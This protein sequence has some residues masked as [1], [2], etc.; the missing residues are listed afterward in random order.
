MSKSANVKVYCRIR[1][2]IEI[3]KQAGL[4]ICINPVSKEAVRI[5][6]EQIP[7]IN[8]YINKE[9]AEEKGYQDFT[10]DAVFG[11]ETNQETVYNNVAK[12]LISAAFEGINCT[13]FCYGQTSSGKTYTIEGIDNNKELLGLIPRAT[14]EIFDIISKG[15]EEIEYSVK[16]QYFQIYNEKIIDLIDSSKSDLPIREDK[17]KGIWVED[18]TDRYVDSEHEMLNF[19][20]EGAKNRKFATTQMNKLSSRSHSIFAVTIF[21]RSTITG[22]SKTGKVY[23]VDLAGSEKLGKTG[24]EGGEKLRE[25][26]NINKSIMTLG[27][28]INALSKSQLHVPYRDSKL[29][30]V[31]QESLGGNSLTNLIINCS[32]SSMNQSETLNTLRFGQRAKLIKNKV[33]ANTVPSI[34]ELLMKLEKSE[35]KIKMLEEI[36]EQMNPGEINENE[37]NKEKK[38]EIGKNGCKECIKLKSKIDYFQKTQFQLQSEISDLSKDKEEMLEEINKKTQNLNKM[39]LRTDS[40]DNSVKELKNE[41]NKIYSELQAQMEKCANLSKKIKNSVSKNDIN[42]VE[43]LNDIANKSWIELISNLGVEIKSLVGSQSAKSISITTDDDHDP[44]DIDRDLTEMEE[45]ISKDPLLVSENEK[46]FELYENALSDSA[47]V[48]KT[49]GKNI[50]NSTKK[51]GKKG[52]LKSNQGLLTAKKKGGFK[53][54]KE[55]CVDKGMILMKNINELR[56]KLRE[57]KADFE[58]ERKNEKKN[59]AGN[60]KKEKVKV[61]E[62]TTK[63]PTKKMN[64]VALTENKPKDIALEIKLNKET[65]AKVLHH[66][67]FSS[68]H[69]KNTNKCS[70]I[71]TTSFEILDLI[72]NSY[73]LDKDKLILRLESDVQEYKEK[74][75]LFESQLTSDEKNLHRKIYTLEKNLEQVNVI[76]QQIITQKSVLK[77]E[78]QIYERKLKKK[79][80]K[81]NLLLKTNAELEEKLK[82]KDDKIHAKFIKVIRGSN[83]G[84]ME[85]NEEKN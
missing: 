75:D 4:S 32:P 41:L 31:L 71:K 3:E 12:P 64:K 78:N 36:I 14:H 58:G 68:T 8:N 33:I 54:N 45:E 56:E 79:N 67:Q 38:V 49:I 23:F 20:H 16:C 57:N 82:L 84:K 73:N 13:L 40:L 43:R 34:K 22:S 46:N 70:I 61:T 37:G 69:S 66:K 35:E 11:K 18:C 62:L 51:L 29:T 6:L 7:G 26:Q 24:I 85:E 5:N 30:R 17:S 83:K 28:V 9:K 72:K 27:M 47:A 48:G 80:Y 39:K 74:L 10:Y 76:Y 1:P 44:K 21:Q 65:E 81:I 59:V 55:N 53:E 42:S 60:V 77:I 50:Q 52:V 15:N 63:S 19:F 2:E 25:A